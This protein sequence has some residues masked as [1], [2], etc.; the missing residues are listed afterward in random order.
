MAAS[1]GRGR[2]SDCG[3][4]PNNF[5]SLA[6]NSAT[7]RLKM[8]RFCNHVV[9]G[10]TMGEDLA[11]NGRSKSVQRPEDGV[12]AAADGRTA[13]QDNGETAAPD[14]GPALQ[15]ERFAAGSSVGSTAKE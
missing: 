3:G 9:R 15:Q 12:S 8:K 1:T 5:R 10:L 2:S 13:G 14:A 4:L 6:L 11:V 7:F